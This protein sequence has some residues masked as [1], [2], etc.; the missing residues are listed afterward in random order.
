MSQ[1]VSDMTL[2]PALARDTKIPT[3]ELHIN[4]GNYATTPGQI[5][6]V[7]NDLEVS[8]DLSKTL[9]SHSCTHIFT[10]SN[11][12]SWAFAVGVLKVKKTLKNKTAAFNLTIH[13]QE[14]NQLWDF[15]QAT[16]RVI[17]PGESRTYQW[18]GTHW[19]QI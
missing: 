10:G 14:A 16:S 5:E 13:G 3:G 9:N 1:K 15:E 19:T 12:G 8:S 18:D 17:G 2:I 11:N 6:G 4:T 7:V